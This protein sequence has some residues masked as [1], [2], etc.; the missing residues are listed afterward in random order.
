M[1]VARRLINLTK[2]QEECLFFPGEKPRDAQNVKIKTLH[3]FVGYNVVGNIFV[4]R[5]NYF[6]IVHLFRTCRLNEAHNSTGFNLR[7]DTL[8]R[9]R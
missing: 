4:N 5:S 8:F 2:S 7:Y 6:C 3:D 9:L 1:N